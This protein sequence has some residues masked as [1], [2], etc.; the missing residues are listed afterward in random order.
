MTSTKRP[1]LRTHAF[2]ATPNGHRG[3]DGTPICHCGSLKT[4]AVHRV[5]E[6]T[7]EQRAA[8]ARRIG[9]R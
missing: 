4:A 7:D 5:R 9:D 1:K 8:Q 2:Y 3:Q 6:Q